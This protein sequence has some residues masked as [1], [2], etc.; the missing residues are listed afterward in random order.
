MKVK[1]EIYTVTVTKSFSILD[2]LDMC[3]ADMTMSH[4]RT[5]HR[6]A[7]CLCLPH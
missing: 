2:H 1:N 5:L 4:I 3:P 6:L 7:G